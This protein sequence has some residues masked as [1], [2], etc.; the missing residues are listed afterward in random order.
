MLHFAIISGR[1]WRVGQG[2]ERFRVRMAVMLLPLR[3][4]L[5]FTNYTFTSLTVKCKL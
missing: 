5:S 2:L 3:L 4:R 1:Q